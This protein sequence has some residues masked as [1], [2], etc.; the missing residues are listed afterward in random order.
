MDGVASDIAA[1][2]RISA[3]PTVLKVV[4][5]ITGL[6]LALVARVTQNEWTACATLDRMSFGLHAGDKL[7]V[8]TTLCSE[9]RDSHQP[10]V[11]EHASQDPQFCRHPTPILYGFESYMA[12]PIYRATGEYFGNLCALDS[13]PARLRDEKTIAMMTLF[14][15]LIS[16]Q[17]T[18]EEEH[19]RD[20]TALFEERQSTHD[21][22]EFIAV[23]AHDIKT[24]LTAVVSGSEFLL[25]D[26]MPPLQT[27]MIRRIRDSGKRVVRLV[28]DLLDFARGRFGR[29]IDLSLEETDAVDPLV[30]QV[31]SE[32][33]MTAPGR[34]VH[35]I[36]A[37]RGA[38]RIDQ[39][40]IAQLISNLIGNAIDHGPKDEPVEVQL[41]STCETIVVSV[42]NRGEPIAP[43]IA[44]KVF[45]PFYRGSNG[46][47][48]SSRG[49]GLGLFIASGIAHAHG[50]TL[51]L[52]SSEERGTVFT[53]ELPRGLATSPDQLS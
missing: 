44:E 38:A 19:A 9:V 15:E 31:V 13:A 29:G 27:D 21:R 20:R 52:S 32:V 2:A 30:R 46:S 22:E 5:E 24:P 43:D 11:I 25:M 12:F 47:V 45:R 53:V 33:A 49:L 10:I 18:A 37:I 17:L 8:T 35:V 28:D 50:G 51:T 39:S 14:A 48:H 23:L 40:R 1:V 4:S 36:G 41:S 16:L 3:V 26:P 34:V 7:D 42:V 6:R